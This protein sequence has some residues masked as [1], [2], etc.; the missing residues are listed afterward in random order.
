MVGILSPT[1]PQELGGGAQGRG[2]GGNEVGYFYQ[3][4]QGVGYPEGPTFALF[5]GTQQQQH[6]QED[7]SFWHG[8][9]GKEGQEYQQQVQQ[10]AA[11]W[12]Y[13][14]PEGENMAPFRPPPANRGMNFSYFQ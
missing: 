6:Q 10:D 8:G 9:G 13:Y 1:V 3:E 5:Q 12:G 2:G 4:E 7:W 11:G 14:F